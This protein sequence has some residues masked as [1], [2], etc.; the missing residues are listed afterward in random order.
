MKLRSIGL[1]TDA[2]FAAWDGAVIDRGDY[3]V[4][5]TPTNPTFFWGNHLV[6]P[7]AP[8]PS[9][10][11]AWTTIFERELPHAKHRAFMC[12]RI[13]GE[14]F[15]YAPLRALGFIPDPTCTM[16]LDSESR[17]A[18]GELD[19]E[20]SGPG[21][22]IVPLDVPPFDL[23]DA[24]F[25]NGREGY[26]RFLQIQVERYA[27]MIASGWGRWF[28]IMENGSPIATCGIFPYETACWRF[29]LVAVHPEHRRRGHAA[30]LVAAV[31]REARRVRSAPI[32]I[33]SVPGSDAQRIYARL[34]F[35]PIEHTIA[36][37]RPT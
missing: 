29:Q 28:A 30:S 7:D 36:I 10:I 16:R 21:A 13:D 6:F 32:I 3:V 23:L 26:R 22:E 17:L 18:F 35:A 2:M 34:G 33:G 9:D 15:D 14:R 27:A 24:C 11:D 8:R 5:S 1:A 20:P 25:T 4:V 12:D 37:V 19:G 31:C